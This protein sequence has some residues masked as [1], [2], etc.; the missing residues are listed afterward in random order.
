MIEKSYWLEE[1]PPPPLHPPYTPRR[2]APRHFRQTHL[3]NVAVWSGRDCYNSYDSKDGR[4]R[5]FGGG[6]R[7]RG[8]VIKIKALVHTPNS[9]LILD[10]SYFPVTFIS[11]QCTT[12]TL[13][14]F[15]PFLFF[16]IS[17]SLFSLSLSLS[18]SFPYVSLTLFLSLFL[19]WMK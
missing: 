15:T 13:L 1:S 3:R 7:G 10:S 11:C 16:S 18:L 6:G 2:P 17:L 12:F 9:S 8:R 19:F 14:R 5:G 4:R